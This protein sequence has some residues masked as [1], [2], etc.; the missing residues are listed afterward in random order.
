MLDS[1]DPNGCRSPQLEAQALAAGK[2]VVLIMNK[3][4]L[5]PKPVVKSWLDVLRRQ[6]PTIAF[7]ASTQKQRSNIGRSNSVK[8]SSAYGADELTKMLSAFAKRKGIKTGVTCAVVG[9]PN[10]GKSSVI[11]SL[12]RSRACQVSAQAGSTRSTQEVAIDKAVRLLGK[13][14]PLVYPYLSSPEKFSF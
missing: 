8:A 5:V 13:C 3:V 11:N 10:V 9:F 12:T 7:K 2:R 6:L 4:D 14:R 1:R